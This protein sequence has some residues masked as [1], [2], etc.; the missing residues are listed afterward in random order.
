MMKRF[1]LRS[2]IIAAVALAMQIGLAPGASSAAGVEQGSSQ[3]QPFKT[4]QSHIDLLGTNFE[5]AVADLQDQIDDLV[6]SQADQDVVIAAIQTAAGLL[7]DRV[8]ANEGDI[9]ALQAADAFQDQLI[10]AL[11]DRLT[12][13]EA[14]VTA[15]EGDIAALILADQTMQALI[16]AIQTQ[17]GTLDAR[18]TANDGD[19]AALQ[20]DIMTL[21]NALSLVQSQLALKQDRVNG[22]CAPGS[23]IRVINADGSVVCEFDNVGAG[24]GTLQGLTVTAAQEI[25]GAGLA[26]GVLILSATCPST[27]VATG[28]GYRFSI[29]S[30]LIT[31]DP[32]LIQV[33]VTRPNGNA[34]E[35]RAINDNV[36]VFGCCRVDLVV[37]ARC[38]KV[39]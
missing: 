25:P 22:V 11:D 6:V 37:Y 27:Y 9:A 20:A 13:L 12:A 26:A 19:I 21:N 16:A 17:I 39:Q 10:Q 7:Q 8:A 4:L 28:G 5:A 2:T 36:I 33:D 35:A 18:I 34:W 24:T 3:G 31:A 30:L 23:S 15:N 1:M 32:R 38:A 14:R 29:R